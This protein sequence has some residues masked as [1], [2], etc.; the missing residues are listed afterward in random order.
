MREEE[1][2]S[3][4]SGNSERIEVG[5]LV[6]VVKPDPC[7]CAIKERFLGTVFRVASLEN[8]ELICDCGSVRDGGL[9]AVDGA[10]GR[11]AELYR[12]RRIPPLSEPET[13][14]ERDEVPV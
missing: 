7:P 4:S 2:V 8:V 11:A 12:L 6:M 5:D 13:V 10:D 14:T 3:A 9:C 1:A